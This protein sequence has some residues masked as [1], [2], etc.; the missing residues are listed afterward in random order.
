MD[1]VWL[2]ICSD[3]NLMRSKLT[4]LGFDVP[5]RRYFFGD[6]S[7]GNDEN[8]A[9]TLDHH[10]N[11]NARGMS[12]LLALWTYVIS[13]DSGR[14][15]LKNYEQFTRST[16]LR[17]RP[18]SEKEPILRRILASRLTDKTTVTNAA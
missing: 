7:Q 15:E 9:G 6:D 12:I 2:T 13:H 8:K 14:Q 16:I 3:M 1:T 4:E 18:E 11:G 10:D 17:R 5:Q